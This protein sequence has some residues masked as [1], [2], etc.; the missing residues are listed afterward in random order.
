LIFAFRS[1][2][3]FRRTFS[4]GPLPSAGDGKGPTGAGMMYQWDAQEY[5][6]SSSEQQKW[7]RE[8]I[9]RLRLRG[10]ETVLDVG[11]GD[12]KVTAEIASL[13]PAGRVVGIDNSGEMVRLASETFPPEA[14]P[15]LIFLLKDATDLDFEEAF[16]LVFSNA[17]LHWVIDHG[18]VLEGI[19]KALRPSG[20]MVMQMGGRGNAAGL[21]ETLHN[22]MAAPKWSPCFEGFVFPYGFHGAVEYRTWVERAGL[23][24]LRV[25]LLPRDM[26][27]PDK[28]ALAAWIRT[29]WLPYTQRLPELMQP[30]FIGD[31]VERYLSRHPADD[32]GTIHVAM[33]RLEVEAEKRS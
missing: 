21:I 4:S 32:D 28:G 29:T 13:L 2:I 17:T 24:P 1:F 25:E 23:D 31:L 5:R 16:D 8:L 7:A 12:G 22:L 30:A 10:N 14:H 3:R 15:N 19:R 11:S 9:A 20:R 27:H 6:K 26:V 18:P 33:V